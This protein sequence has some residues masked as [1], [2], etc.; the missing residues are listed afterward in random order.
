MVLIIIFG[1]YH[2]SVESTVHVQGTELINI[3]FY[4]KYFH[5][6]DEVLVY[7]WKKRISKQNISKVLVSQWQ[8]IELKKLTEIFDHYKMRGFHMIIADH[9]R[10]LGSLVNCSEIVA[11]TDGNKIFVFVSNHQR[12][13]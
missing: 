13:Q 10:L 1:G 7:C 2:I 3:E 4:N 8:V 5:F 11:I 9:S 6:T 12:S